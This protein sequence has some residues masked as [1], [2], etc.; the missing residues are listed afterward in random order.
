MLKHGN[1]NEVQ[2]KFVTYHGFSDCRGD[3]FRKDFSHIGEVRSILPS[4]V[5]IMALTAT[6]MANTRK[7]VVSQLCME[8]PAVVYMPPAKS[9]IFYAVEERPAMGLIVHRIADDLIKH[10]NHH[11]HILLGNQI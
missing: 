3:S 4:H 9:N 1:I 6:A 8:D 11:L 10:Q 7:Y 2:Y 5:K